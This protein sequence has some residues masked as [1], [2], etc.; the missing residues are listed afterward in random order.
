MYT[1]LSYRANDQLFRGGYC[2]G[3]T[4]SDLRLG[5]VADR[6][7]AIDLLARAIFIDKVS[8][9][10]EINKEYEFTSAWYIALG[11]N[12]YFGSEHSVDLVSDEV[13]DNYTAENSAMFEEAEVRASKLYDEKMVEYREEKRRKEQQN[14]EAAARRQEAE[15]RKQLARLKEKYGE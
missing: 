11:I 9:N 6:D 2:E 1:V 13:Y 3:R 15:E 10:R 4:D 5:T 14:Q 7:E 12:G 8:Q